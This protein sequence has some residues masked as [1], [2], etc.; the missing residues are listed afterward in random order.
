MD[1]ACH[2]EI[3]LIR[4]DDNHLVITD[5]IRKVLLYL[6]VFLLGVLVCFGVEL[7]P[8]RVTGSYL[9]IQVNK[10]SIAFYVLESQQRGRGG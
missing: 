2:A 8:I 3:Q 4:K 10:Q 1:I 9:F 6:L 7:D 5:T